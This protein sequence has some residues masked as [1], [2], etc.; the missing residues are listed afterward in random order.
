MEGPSLPVSPA[1]PYAARP[2]ML[3]IAS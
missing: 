3:L 2:F 1:R